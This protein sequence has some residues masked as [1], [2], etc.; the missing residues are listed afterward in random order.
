MVEEDLEGEF[1]A[2]PLGFEG[3]GYRDW[4]D[5]CRNSYS[6]N[7]EGLIRVFEKV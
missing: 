5:S 3:G 4:I 6:Q 1:E 7:F 2:F